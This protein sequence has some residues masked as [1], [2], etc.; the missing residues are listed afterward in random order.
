MKNHNASRAAFIARAA[1]L[2]VLFSVLSVF[3]NSAPAL[4]A[5]ESSSPQPSA[6]PARNYETMAKNTFFAELGGAGLIYSLNYDRLLSPSWSVRGGLSFLGASVGT[7]SSSAG[8]GLVTIPLTTSYL[9]NL[10]GSSSHIELGGGV[11]GLI[12][13][14]SG[15]VFGGTNSA[16]GFLPMITGIVGYRLQPAEGGFNFRAGVTPLLFLPAGGSLF[17]TSFAVSAGYTF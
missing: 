17:F 13:S 5:Q 14:V 11:T 4:L 1:S 15:T 9:F 3:T 16:S 10:G 8:F 12:G 2:V 6:A 7:G